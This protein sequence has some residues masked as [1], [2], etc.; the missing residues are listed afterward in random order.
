M[1]ADPMH[2][3]PGHDRILY[4]RQEAVQMTVCGRLPDNFVEFDVEVRQG[5]RGPFRVSGNQ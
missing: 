1:P 4:L 3:Y 5:F 2:L